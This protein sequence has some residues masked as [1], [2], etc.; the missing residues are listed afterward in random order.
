MKKVLSFSLWGNNPTYNIGA[1][2]N[3]E[4]AKNFYPDF[5]CW[6]Y[7]HKDT[8]PQETI[9]TLN[10]FTNTKIIFKTGDLNNEN[11]KPRMWRYEPI[12][13]L[14]VEVVLSRDTDT[15]ILFREKFAV[16]EWLQS[17][18]L[19]HIMRDHPHH[20]FCILA[21]MFGTKKIPQIPNW[22]NLI[23]SYNKTDNR[24]YDQDFLR[25]IIYPIIKDDS[26]IHATFHK[27]EPHA[28]NF[29]INYHKTYKFV[30]EY[31]YHDDSRSIEHIN[32]LKQRVNSYKNRKIEI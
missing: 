14:E 24:M 31:V 13:E 4:L 11:C 27:Y 18:K 3:A 8:V 22:I 16:E 10:S 20:G 2:K 6:F 23:N 30:G 1:I 7:I 12:D 28:K 29:P 9:D 26:I 32:I 25:D 19:F 15:R 21:G 5:E 17:G